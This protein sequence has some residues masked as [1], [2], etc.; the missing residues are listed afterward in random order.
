VAFLSIVESG[1]AAEGLFGANTS[2]DQIVITS[3]GTWVIDDK[4]HIITIEKD[5][6]ATEGDFTL[7]CQQMVIHYVK[8][9]AGDDN[10]GIESNITQIIGSGGVVITTPS[11]TATSERFKYDRG[12]DRLTLSGNPVLRRGRSTF[13]G[14]E[15]IF[16][17]EDEHVEVLSC[18]GKKSEARIF[19]EDR[20]EGNTIMEER[21]E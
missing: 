4:K 11:G 17:L 5:V 19:P 14:C 6:E 20:D 12:Q 1:Y 2:D 16:H 21:G 8:T 10:S 18:G 3:K 15:V 7:N 9:G 13:E